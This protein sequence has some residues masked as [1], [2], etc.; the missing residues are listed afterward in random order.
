VNY[1]IAPGDPKTWR[2]LAFE[3]LTEFAALGCKSGDQQIIAAAR[4]YS[5]LAITI[6][7]AEGVDFPPGGNGAVIKLPLYRMSRET[8]GAA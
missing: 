3:L 6:R 4:R 2:Q 1:D 8:P 7:E 5:T